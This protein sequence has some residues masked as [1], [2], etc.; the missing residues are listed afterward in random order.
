MEYPASAPA[1]PS[2]ILQ[3][4]P[5]QP[6]SQ[7][8][9]KVHHLAVTIQSSNILTGHQA[10]QGSIAAQDEQYHSKIQELAVVLEGAASLPLF[11]STSRGSPVTAA[12]A[13]ASNDR[14]SPRQ[15]QAA[16]NY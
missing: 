15:Q 2:S 14:I 6:S 9:E 8:R 10:S 13:P 5:Q 12:A 1:S 16:I 11:H 7:M 3:D 4:V